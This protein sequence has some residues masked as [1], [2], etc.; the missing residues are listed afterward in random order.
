M[1]SLCTE[2]LPHIACVTLEY[3]E[4]IELLSTRFC[5]IYFQARCDSELRMDSIEESESS[6][7]QGCGG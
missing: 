4:C 5:Q 6:I 3:A 2:V 1:E 7:T